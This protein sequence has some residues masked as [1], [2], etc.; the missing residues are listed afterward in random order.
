MASEVL[1]KVCA[2]KQVHDRERVHKA[3]S[4]LLQEWNLGDALSAQGDS[5][6]RGTSPGPLRD[7]RAM[8]GGWRIV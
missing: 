6:H 5:S 3:A 8:D 1:W 2:I 7:H 4:A